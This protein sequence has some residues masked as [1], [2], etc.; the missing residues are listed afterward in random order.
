LKRKQ[1]RFKKQKQNKEKKKKKK[2]KKKRTWFFEEGIISLLPF[3]PCSSHK[4]PHSIQGR[5][6]LG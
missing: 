3:P 1:S 2:K 6:L 5:D 4:E